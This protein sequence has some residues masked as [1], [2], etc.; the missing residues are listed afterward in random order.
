MGVCFDLEA[1]FDP[2][3]LQFSNGPGPVAQNAGVPLTSQNPVR[4]RIADNSER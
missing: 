3:S 2:Y 1:G 4:I